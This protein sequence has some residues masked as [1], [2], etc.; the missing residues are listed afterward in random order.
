MPQTIILPKSVKIIPHLCR[1]LRVGEV[2]AAP[3]ETAYG[4]LVDATNAR[5]VRQV[6]KIKGREQG[7]PIAL[8]A[9]SLR[10]V[11][12]YFRMT[13]SELRLANKFW[14]GPLTLLLKPRR[15]FPEVIQ[16]SHGLV[17]VRVPGSVWLRRLVLTANVPLTATSANRAGGVTIYTPTAV[18]RA[19]GARGLKFIVDGGRLKVRPTSTVARINKDVLEILRPGAVSSERLK[20]VVKL[21]S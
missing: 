3:T 10:M 12:R 7:K 1:L 17:G 13:S 4:L 15:K 14:P 6:V 21:K 16:G 18:R 20:R 5:A 8:V 2:V 9:S 11:K 19:L